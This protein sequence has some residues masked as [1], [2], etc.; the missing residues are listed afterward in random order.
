MK[1]ILWKPSRMIPQAGVSLSQ[2][3]MV[4]LECILLIQMVCQSMVRERTRCKLTTLDTLV[5][6]WE[7]KMEREIPRSVCFTENFH[8]VIVFGLE[9]GT[10]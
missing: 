9:E 6:I 1:A 3:T 8:S 5:K 7:F 10:M 2:A 4:L